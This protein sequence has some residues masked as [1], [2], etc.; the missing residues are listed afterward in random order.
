MTLRKDGGRTVYMKQKNI[1]KILNVSGTL[2]SL[3][4]RGKRNITYHQAKILSKL[5]LKSGKKKGLE[6]W[7]EADYKDIKKAFK[8]LK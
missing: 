5:K 7:M 4:G 6:F 1:A 8:L 3:I 2:I